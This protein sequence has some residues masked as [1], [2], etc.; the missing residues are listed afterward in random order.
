MLQ[1]LFTWL[2]C[3]FPASAGMD[4]FFFAAGWLLHYTIFTV[5]GLLKP[6]ELTLPTRLIAVAV[7][8]T[9][10]NCLTAP[11][12]CRCF[13]CQYGLPLVNCYLTA[14]V[15][16]PLFLLLARINSFHPGWLLP[17]YWGV[18]KGEIA[19]ETINRLAAVVGSDLCDRKSCQASPCIG[20]NAW[21][22]PRC[23]R[24]CG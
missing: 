23:S 11:L 19:V 24:W 4:Q 15:V 9:P 14:L 1:S 2:H 16:F 22:Y 21:C 8:S 12:P 7:P 5:T 6:L 10:I 13:F 3:C 18:G 20:D 17:L